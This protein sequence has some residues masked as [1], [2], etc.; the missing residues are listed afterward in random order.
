MTQSSGTPTGPVAGRV[1][2]HFGSEVEVRFE[3]G[4]RKRIRIKP[5][6]VA[7]VVGDCVRLT[8]AGLEA[9]PRDTVLR[10]RDAR[11]RSRVIAAN[12]DVLGIV[13][14]AEP[15]APKGYIDRAIVAARAAEIEP[16]LIANKRD[17]EDSDEVAEQLRQTYAV[18][19]AGI[20]V[21]PVSAKQADGLD[22]LRFFFSA[23]RRGAFI[24][25]SG[26]GK[27]SLL[28]AL[29]PGL[30]LEVGEINRLTKLGRHV[31]ARSTLHELSGG[32]E[33]IDTPGFRDFVPEAVSPDELATRFA[34]FEEVLERGCRFRNCLHRDEPRCSVAEGV[35]EGVIDPSRHSAYLD[36]LADLERLE[37]SDRTRRQDR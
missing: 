35:A 7:L 32:G 14:C 34:G 6:D 31:T 1:V 3:H 23:D 29:I 11:G 16:F 36:I 10:R 21:F 13:V 5:R 33:L 26:V 27:S 19:A 37:E 22:G 4:V 18:A 15:A 17:L 8:D 20:P 25:T 2:G 30:D 9:L 28:N 12:L 24:G